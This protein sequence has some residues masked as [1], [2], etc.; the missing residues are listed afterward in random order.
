MNGST[1]VTK[2]TSA[3]LETYEWDNPWWEH[4]EITDKPRVLYIGDSISRGTLF[5]L[6]KLADGKILFDNFA[7][8]K[9]LDNPF[10]IPSLELFLSQ[11]GR[12]DCIIFNNG[13]HG[14]HLSDEEYA[15]G[16]ENMLRYLEKKGIP[17]YVMLTTHLPL[18]EEREKT[19]ISRNAAASAAAAKHGFGIID[20]HRVSSALSMDDYCGDGV[21][22]HN[23]GYEALAKEILGSI[24]L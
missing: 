7:T 15:E 2:K 14:W 6:N 4:T 16:F 22:F 1:C 20:L 24:K 19:V 23:E 3:A 21:H 12:C 9:A 5:P 13:L 11:T 10:F 8:S 17:V 18:D